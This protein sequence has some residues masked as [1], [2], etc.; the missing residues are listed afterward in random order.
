MKPV[1]F[2]VSAM[3]AMTMVAGGVTALA[4][5][6][7]AA[8]TLAAQGHSHGA[9]PQGNDGHGD[10]A[11]GHGD[12]P[13]GNG[14]HEGSGGSRGNAGRESLTGVVSAVS[15]SGFTMT[16]SAQPERHGH[17]DRNSAG[18]A[19]SAPV[20]VTVTSATQ[21][22]QPGVTS[23]AVAV[24]E[25]VEVR[26]ARAA[27][28][29]LDA[30]VVR[31]PDVALSGTVSAVSATVG[32]AGSSLTLTSTST[33]LPGLDKLAALT[34]TAYVVDISATTKLMEPGISSPSVG[35]IVAGDVVDVAGQ[36]AGTDAS[37]NTTIDAVRV[38]LPEVAAE[39]T[40]DQV[41][42]SGFTLV[43]QRKPFMFPVFGRGELDA[44]GAGRRGDAGATTYPE[45]TVNV[46]SATKFGGD[47]EASAS[48][49]GSGG[50]G[51]LQ[52]GDLV[53]VTGVQAGAS[54][55][56]ASK[57]LSMPSGHGG[58]RGGRHGR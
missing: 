38:V 31:I 4:G 32:A 49:S 34:A 30:T 52:H 57:V 47:R 9:G 14:R 13:H 50:L 20:V 2:L 26:G 3:A 39:G 8:P 48:A 55:V 37:G 17:G 54:T 45:I 28:G 24:G 27:D 7:L 22:S 23:P 35:A 12:G 36:Q 15:S 19:S 53:R 1:R 21:I 46:T 51:S 43:P 10:G 44:H 41:G 16:V 56:D 29:S 6:A 25:L 40:V 33:T 58:R 5:T 42:T 18:T 11:H